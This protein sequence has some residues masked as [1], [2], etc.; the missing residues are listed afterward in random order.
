MA[1]WRFSIQGNQVNNGKQTRAALCRNGCNE[2]FKNRFW[3]PKLQ[4][5]RTEACP[6]ANQRECDNYQVMCGCL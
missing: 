3:C 2:P 6:F 4:W 5:F 1:V